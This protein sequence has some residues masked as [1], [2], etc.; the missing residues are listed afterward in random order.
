MVC[1]YR[2][3]EQKQKSSLYLS[4][5]VFAEASDISEQVEYPDDFEED[6]EKDDCE[7]VADVV[8]A[9]ALQQQ[10]DDSLDEF[11]LCDAGGLTITLKAL[12]EKG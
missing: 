7:G 2:N 10:H 5:T 9:S 4:L 8:D 12:K 6:E 1:L 3:T 11:Q